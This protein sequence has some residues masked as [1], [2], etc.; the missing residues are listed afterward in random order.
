MRGEGRGS[1]ALEM[2]WIVQRLFFH[3]EESTRGDE[4][5]LLVQDDFVVFDLSLLLG[6]QFKGREGGWEGGC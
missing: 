6:L 1:F 5:A 3:V 4:A 2:S